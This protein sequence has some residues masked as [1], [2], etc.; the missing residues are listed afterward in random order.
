MGPE[1]LGLGA[2]DF[3]RGGHC[4]N[5]FS[6]QGT[7]GSVKRSWAKRGLIRAVMLLTALG[8]PLVVNTEPAWA[9]D[10]KECLRFE[11]VPISVEEDAASLGELDAARSRGLERTSQL[12]IAQVIGVKIEALRE[13]RAEINNST[14]EQRFA[15]HEQSVLRG[16][17]RLKVIE[18]SRRSTD[19]GMTL[20]LKS[21]ATVC[22]P[23]PEV[24]VKAEREKAE[25][26]RRAPQQV[27]P[28]TATWFNPRSGEA[29]IWYWRSPNQGYEFFDNFGFH[30]RTGDKLIPVDRKVVADWKAAIQREQKATEE[31]ARQEQLR[32]QAE[33]E[34]QQ[35]LSQAPD[36]CDQ[37]AASPYDLDKPKGVPG[38]PYE[39]LKANA[40]EAVEVCQA[41]AQQ[42]PLERRFRYQLARTYQVSEPKKAL[43]ILQTLVGQSYR[44]A[45]DNYGWALLDTRVGRDD[46]AGAVTSF[47]RGA[48]LGDPDSMHSLATLIVKGRAT[49]QRPNE[50]IQL[51]QR[52]ASLG[53]NEAAAAL[54]EAA[55]AQQQI[56]TQRLQNEQAAKMFMGIVGGVL[57][58]ARR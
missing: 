34:R 38:V 55:A 22:V 6:Q 47:R 48:A 9:Y 20:V 50:V 24:M 52:A 16:L 15:E 42:Y 35:R 10:D 4:P 21:E 49:P 23:K 54:Q 17:V 40:P 29:Q 26:E 7:N 39:L 45:F 18:E 11:T 32:R 57:G 43:S 31:R 56:E 30:P 8:A 3:M 41:A 2:T 37:L 14:A 1:G 25:R 27:D 13:N 51:Y 46:L 53:H 19:Q 28:A 12:A 44:A 5:G 58:N 36:L 33:V